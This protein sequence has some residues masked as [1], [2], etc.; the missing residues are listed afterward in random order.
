[1]AARIVLAH[2]FCVGF[3][4]FLTYA[5][6]QSG[7]WPLFVSGEVTRSKLLTLS[8]VCVVQAPS[9]ASNYSDIRLSDPMLS[10]QKLRCLLESE[11]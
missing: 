3:G 10:F 9:D 6:V 5:C 7:L 4:I 8:R 2:C 1:M 11:T